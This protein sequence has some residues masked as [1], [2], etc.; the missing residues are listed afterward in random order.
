MRTVAK[1]AA[2]MAIA[3]SSLACFY[4]AEIGNGF[5]VF[6]GDSYD[7]MIEVSILQHWANVFAGREAWNLTRYFYPA[8]DTLGYNDGY[9][10]YGALFTLLRAAGLPLIAA[11]DA[12]HA[13]IK[14]VG[15][16]G[17]Y[18]LLRTAARC[19]FGWSLFGA[20]LFSIAD[21]TL[22]HANHGQLFTAAFTPWALIFVHGAIGSIR[23]GDRRRLLVFGGCFALLYASWISTAFYLAWFF[24]LYLIVLLAV[25][26][27][28]MGVAAR[29]R[30]TGLILGQRLSLGLLAVLQ[31][32]LLI[33]FLTVYLPKA[34]ESGMHSFAAVGGSAFWPFDYVNQGRTN[35]LWSR[36]FDGIRW[37]VPG[38]KSN[39]DDIFGIAPILFLSTFYGAYWFGRREKDAVLGASVIA[40][41]ICWLLMF[42][43]I[44]ILVYLLVPGAR[45]IRVVG[46]FDLVLLVPI[47]AIATRLLQRLKRGWWAA[48]IAL[49]LLA[50]EADARSPV[51]LDQ[52]AQLAMIA[53][54]RGRIGPECKSFYV[55]SSRAGGYPVVDPVNDHRYAHNVDAMIL[56]EVIAKP[57]VNGFSTFLPPHWDFDDAGSSTYRARVRRYARA[58]GIAMPCE[59]AV[60]AR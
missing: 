31:I 38:L 49:L 10:V 16:A 41:L 51:K 43:G 32:V 46:R 14:L 7:A 3:A 59:L 45:G 47:I 15:F 29:R 5:T 44:W 25:L 17:M 50:E 4:R 28:R 57:T 35:L 2:F 18:L 36:F 34:G 12:V 11:A 37:I 52:A 1:V 22:Q 42:R 48:V 26:A 6:F 20:V 40:V 13:L 19:R 60:R 27:A 33:P 56:S 9:I 23:N 53:G 54:A 24:G 58:M 21:I 30:W 8:T 39:P 55:T